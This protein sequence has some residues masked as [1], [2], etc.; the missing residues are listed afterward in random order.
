MSAAEKLFI[1][2]LMLGWGPC[3]GICLPVLLPY[4]I[5]TEKGWKNGFFASLAFSVSRL[6]AYAILG[7]LA[8]YAAKLLLNT[9]YTQKISYY[10]TASG[11]IVIIL[12]GVLITAGK[13]FEIPLCNL[14]RK[15]IIERGMRG[16]ILLGLLVGF[17]PC[18]P[19]AGILTFIILQAK[20]GIE[21]FLY[22][23]VF[24][25]GTI[26]SPVLLLGTLAGATTSYLKKFHT[27]SNII[28]RACGVLLVIWGL[29]ILL[30]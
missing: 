19:L 14:L 3:L 20:S 8:G 15:H 13:D 5:G 12:L 4:I 7:F 11:A 16:I 22:G 26:L 10:I 1:T 18:A 25:L 30:R 29:Q 9:F 27:L 24:G 17:S 2:G 23:S 28:S 21:G 6:I